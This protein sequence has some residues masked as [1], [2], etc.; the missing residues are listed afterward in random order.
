MLLGSISLLDLFERD[1]IYAEELPISE[2]F[3]MHRECDHTIGTVF[4][5][6]N[7]RHLGKVASCLL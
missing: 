2:I 3:L 7:V 5:Q 1:D 6:V 4:R